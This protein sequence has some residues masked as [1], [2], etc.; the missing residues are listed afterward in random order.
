MKKIL[1]VLS[2]CLLLIS[3]IA[4]AATET[5]KVYSLDG[6]G[7]RYE[8]D[9]WI[10]VHIE[11]EPFERG[12]QHGYLV[13]DQ[14]AEIR[15][16]L[17][18][19]TY[20]DS[21]KDWGFFVEQA[22]KMWECHIDSEI[23][24]E[25][26]GIA[27][28][29]TYAGIPFTWQEIMAWNGYEELMDY[30]WPTEMERTYN[31]IHPG[32]DD[33]CSAFMAVGSATKGG[34]IVMAH[35]SFNN[36]EWGQ[37]ANVI[38]DIVPAD[39]FRIFMQSQ[40]GYIHSMADFFIT[41]AK[42]MGTETTIGGFKEYDE[43]G[44]PEFYRV[45]KAMQYSTTLDEFVGYMLYENNGGYANTWMVGDIKTNE[46]MRFELGL[47]F[48]KVD[49]TKDGYFIGF[50][51][52]LDPRI[53]NLECTNTGYADIRRHQGARQVRLE[54]LMEQYY[55]GID[56]EIGKVVLGDHYDV[57]LHK[58]NPCSRTIDAHYE[59]DAREYMSETGRP[60]PFRPRGAV[61]G[62][63]C[64]SDMALNFTMWARWGNSSGTPFDASEFLE[65]HI[66]W[67]YLEGYLIDRPTQP[68]SLFKAGK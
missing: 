38:L 61:D 45:R 44:A 37:F 29:T 52:P 53:R 4:L 50:N 5:E 62:K 33:R 56:A 6:K 55:S 59:L 13:A 58:I 41:G 68:W 49:R 21:G 9:G 30:W 43:S 28:G 63:V 31:K 57:Y 27:A 65:E 22:E 24:Q 42:L 34:K 18:Y 17:E 10:Y 1:L 46:I 26:C 48:Y 35:N 12:F 7:Y 23:M 15:K 32:A 3:T 39:G 19:L 54:E 20:W 51:A 2:L 25:I 60:L 67:D 66:Q 40:A 8:K 16:S 14:L 11:G 64:D 36:F 47:K